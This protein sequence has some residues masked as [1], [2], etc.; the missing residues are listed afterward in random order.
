MFQTM[1]YVNSRMFIRLPRVSTKI[2]I[3]DPQSG[4]S[5]G[6]L[7]VFGNGLRNTTTQ[8]STFQYTPPANAGDPFELQFPI[9]VSASNSPTLTVHSP[10]SA[11]LLGWYDH[12]AVCRCYQQHVHLWS[13]FAYRLG[14]CQEVG[15]SHDV[16]RHANSDTWHFSPLAIYMVALIPSAVCELLS[17][18]GYH[19]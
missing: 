3:F 12:Q 2:G 14:G 7:Y 8:P 13:Q 16:G 4:D 10:V 1:V 6:Y 9:Q 19:T 5:L 18:F 17:K 15:S 11:P